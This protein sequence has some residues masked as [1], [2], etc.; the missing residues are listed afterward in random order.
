M[1]KHILLESAITEKFAKLQRLETP[2]SLG[3]FF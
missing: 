2:A 3:L 1:R